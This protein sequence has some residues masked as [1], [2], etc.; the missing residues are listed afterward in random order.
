MPGSSLSCLLYHIIFSVKNRQTKIRNPERNRLFQ[1]MGG[2]I[3]TIGGKPV[4]IN[5]MDDHV[6]LLCFLPRHLSIS[7]MVKTIKGKSSW[8][9]N[10]TFTDRSFPFHWQE[11]YCVFSVS[12]EAIDKVKHYILQQDEHHRSMTYNDEF[13]RYYDK[14]ISVQGKE[15]E[16]DGSESD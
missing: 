10:R 11:G 5:G 1:Y 13:M 4:I 9:L 16:G 7:E 8:W 2:I 14:L 3:N 12:P 15:E 6:H